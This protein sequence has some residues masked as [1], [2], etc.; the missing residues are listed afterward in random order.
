MP[1]AYGASARKGEVIDE[2][3]RQ[4]W[5]L[6]QRFKLSLRSPHPTSLFQ[7]PVQ[8]VPPTRTYGDFL[9]YVLEHSKAFFKRNEQNGDLI[10]DRAFNADGVELLIVH[11][12]SW[13]NEC[14]LLRKEV[15]DCG[16][17]LPKEA[18]RK[19][20]FVSEKEAVKSFVMNSP[21]E[22]RVR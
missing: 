20:H 6:A 10:W 1:Q 2:A 18:G 14:V 22:L 16:L 8:S 9:A 7:S 17:M 12:Q 4:G 5:V 19:V 11:P 15:V 13:T 21:I 3:Q